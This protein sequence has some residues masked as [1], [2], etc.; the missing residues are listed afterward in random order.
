[1][2]SIYGIMVFLITVL[3]CNTHTVLPNL[4][5][6]ITLC[7][8]SAFRQ[9]TG[10]PSYKCFK[11]VYERRIRPKAELLSLNHHTNTPWH[12]TGSKIKPGPSRQLLLIDEFFLVMMRLRLGLLESDLA[13]RF[14]IYQQQVSRIIGRWLPCLARALKKWIYIPTKEQVSIN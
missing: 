3:K 14:S 13:E 2:H 6:L 8:I 5:S 11:A 1:M 10:F 12:K 4:F 7:S 9:F